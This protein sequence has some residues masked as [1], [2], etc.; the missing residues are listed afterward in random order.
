MHA[1]CC[2]LLAICWIVP[3]LLLADAARGTPEDPV[4]AYEFDVPR[5]GWTLLAFS[6]DGGRL[7]IA[8]EKTVRF[9]DG[10]TGQP[11]DL[12]IR[13]E[14][15]ILR[16]S[17]S[18]DRRRIVTV[19]D[20]AIHF[21]D[22]ATGEPAG[23]DFKFD[24]LLKVVEFTPDG[25]RVLLLRHEAQ[26][27]DLSTGKAVLPPLRHPT[28]KAKPRGWLSSWLGGAG[29]PQPF[30]DT[31]TLSPDGT[32]VLT[33]GSDET[34]RLWDA[35]TG[36]A[37]LPPMPHHGVDSPPIFSADGTR[38]FTIGPDGGDHAGVVWDVATGR[39]IARLGKHSWSNR[40]VHAAFSPDGKRVATG[41][42]HGHIARVWDADTGKPVGRS[43]PI[44]GEEA[45]RVS[46]SLDGR[47]LLVYDKDA[48]MQ[49][50]FDATSGEKLQS[51][52]D[53]YA[54]FSPD[55]ELLLTLDYEAGIVRA[56]D[57]RKLDELIAAE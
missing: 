36:E 34:A 9:R 8:D 47:K 27:V 31:A 51:T 43:L 24:A 16:V 10:K 21:W 20:G 46:F 33:S 50:L 49:F 14:N 39:E 6:P 13:H 40:I 55:G 3:L 42:A 57:L 17:F 15:R 44:V 26:L 53:A 19:T 45:R 22:A 29:N 5:R 38:V 23:P 2:R 12:S 7:A 25:K 18:P 35:A 28:P 52:N 37:L 56:L 1:P 41:G 32:K 11:L 54:E 48:G 4:V 30:L